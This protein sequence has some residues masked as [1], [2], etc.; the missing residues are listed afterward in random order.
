M[1][2]THIWLNVNHTDLLTCQNIFNR[3]HTSAI[4]MTSQLPKLN[5]PEEQRWKMCHWPIFRIKKNILSDIKLPPQ[6]NIVNQET[7]SVYAHTSILRPPVIADHGIKLLSADKVIFS[8]RFLMA[9]G[10]PCG[11]WVEIKFRH[12]QN[13]YSCI[14]QSHICSIKLTRN[15]SLV[16]L[17][18]DLN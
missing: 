12:L 2:K 1:R 10:W 8:A 6:K 9:F 11:I 15:G 14:T 4:E 3:I 16:D 13:Q 18:I 5:E 7:S 17:W